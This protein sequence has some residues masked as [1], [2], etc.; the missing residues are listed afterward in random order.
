MVFEEQGA[1]GGPNYT[2]YLR[3]MDA[4]PAIKLG[5]GFCG[6]ISPD[7]KYV[8]TQL[9]GK[10]N[11]INLLPTGAG[12]AKVITHPNISF[13]FGNTRWFQDSNR[14]L[15]NARETGKPARHWICNLASGKIV[16]ATPEGVAGPAL[17]SSDQS[18]VLA[19]SPAGFFFIPWTA[20][21]QNRRWAW[22]KA[23]RRS[24]GPRIIVPSLCQ[25][26]QI[27]ASVYR[28]DLNTGQRTLWK[29]LHLPM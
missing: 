11:Q 8:A 26:R 19:E 18:S 17:I 3:K 12:E 25:S 14:L 1:G 20:V 27:P 21:L 16:L 13:L 9:P 23:T 22:N 15:V 6:P 5:E 2:V 24:N 10:V 4:S 28:V 29:E 7:G